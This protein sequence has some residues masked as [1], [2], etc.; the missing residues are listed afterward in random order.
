MLIGQTWSHGLP[1]QS[2]PP[3]PHVKDGRQ[4]PKET[5]GV[6]TPRQRPWADNTMGARYKM[7]LVITIAIETSDHGM[8]CRV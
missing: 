3:T 2:T 7:G 1:P 8:A 4:F 6:V 5:S